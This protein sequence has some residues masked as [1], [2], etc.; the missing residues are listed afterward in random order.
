MKENKSA[1]VKVRCTHGDK[2]DWQAK[3]KL[4]GLPMSELIR[5]SLTRVRVWS[6]ETRHQH[7]VIVR[8]LA[9]IGNNVN[10]IARGVNS[11]SHEPIETIEIITCLINLNENLEKYVSAAFG[12]N[13]DV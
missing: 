13:N 11:S 7:A 3:A 8:H 5:E 1:I 2:R 10:Q 6:P 12:E 9:F 4:A